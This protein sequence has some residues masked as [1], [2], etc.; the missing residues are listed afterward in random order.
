M[1]NRRECRVPFS[2]SVRIVG[3]SRMGQ[4][5]SGTAQTLDI[6][7]RG[8]RLSNA[9]F[10]T[11]VGEIVTLQHQQ[12]RAKFRVVWIGDKQGRERGLAGLELLA[13]QA[14]IWGLDPGTG[15]PDTFDPSQRALSAKPA[16]PPSPAPARVAAPPSRTAC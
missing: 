5:S 11:C 14:P 13:G 2:A 9:E 16:V 4:P 12:R 10:L 7:R 3:A 15:K 6:S 8:V 1:A